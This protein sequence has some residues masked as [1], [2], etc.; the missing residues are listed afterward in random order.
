MTRIEGSN[1]TAKAILEGGWGV[2][3]FNE[4]EKVRIRQLNWPVGKTNEFNCIFRLLDKGGFEGFN[5]A[6]YTSWLPSDVGSFVV[7]RGCFVFDFSLAA[8]NIRRLFGVNGEPKTSDI[9][10]SK[11]PHAPFSLL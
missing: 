1:T 6:P 2:A 8:K 9:D 4:E 11:R 3:F 10:N 5:L 7:C